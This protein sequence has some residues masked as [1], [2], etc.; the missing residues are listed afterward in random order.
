MRMIEII[1]A[2]LASDKL[3]A[4]EK[5][6]RLINSS[7]SNIEYLVD[8][9]KESLAEIVKIETMISKWNSYT[10]PSANAPSANNNNNNN[11]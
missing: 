8:E 2:E 4:E 10:A 5:L 9:I 7:E 6:Q 11:N 1:L 3:K